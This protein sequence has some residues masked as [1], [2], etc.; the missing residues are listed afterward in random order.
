MAFINRD[1][2]RFDIIGET[3]WNSGRGDEYKIIVEDDVWIGNGAII[4]SPVRI[5]RGAII[6][7]GSGVTEDIP[8][9][10]VVAGNPARV[11]KMRF[12][13]EQIVEH[14]R[15]LREHSEMHSD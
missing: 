4:L 11:L 8:Q 12:T 15:I 9:Y 6:A 2:H 14:E 1:D 3:I 5:G 7:A 13:P 10:A